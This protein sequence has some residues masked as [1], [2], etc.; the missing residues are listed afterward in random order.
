[1]DLKVVHVQLKQ[2]KEGQQEHY[3][4]GSLKA[5]FE[6]LTK[7]DIGRN[8]STLIST[9][10]EKAGGVLETRKAIIRIGELVRSKMNSD[11]KQNV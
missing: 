4:F 6:V 3:Y 9:S 5:I 11:D 8:Y 10:I 7:E 1:M 2:P